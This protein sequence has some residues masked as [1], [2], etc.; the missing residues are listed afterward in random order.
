MT[1]GGPEMETPREAMATIGQGATA[2]LVATG[3]AVFVGMLLV[4]SRRAEGR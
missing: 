3:V 4:L 1:T 2:L